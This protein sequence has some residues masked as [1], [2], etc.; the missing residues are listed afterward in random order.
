VF[1]DNRNDH[2]AVTRFRNGIESRHWRA[3]GEVR[4][5]PPDIRFQRKGPTHSGLQSQILLRSHGRGG[6]SHGVVVARPLALRVTAKLVTRDRFLPL[7]DNRRICHRFL[8]REASLDGYAGECPLLAGHATPP[9]PFRRVPCHILVIIPS[10]G[11][12]QSVTA[13][14]DRGEFRIGILSFAANDSTFA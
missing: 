12:E 7:S 14:A 9:R 3:G 1:D 11:H 4:I 8:A 13:S 5:V 10:D 6:A 2:G